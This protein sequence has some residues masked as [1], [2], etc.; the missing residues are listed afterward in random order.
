MN[1]RLLVDALGWGLI[2]W[3]IGF[4]LGIV[5]FPFIPLWAIGWA[6]LPIG[7]AVALWILYRRIK[8]ETLQ[9]YLIVGVVW[10]LIAVLLDYFIM[11]KM[12]KPAD[13]YYKVDVYL[14]YAL[15]F[16]LPLLVGWRKLANQK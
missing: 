2:L 8:G 15:T 11:V 3:L 4:V 14:Y 1:K 9:Y 13:G 6:I 12:L 16:V 5:L 7:V 10:T